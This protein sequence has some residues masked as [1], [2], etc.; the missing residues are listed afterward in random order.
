[1]NL[2]PES[3]LFGLH[4]IL[5]PPPQLRQARL[6]FHILVHSSSVSVNIL[7]C[8]I[9]NFF[10]REQTIMKG[11]YMLYLKIFSFEINEPFLIKFEYEITGYTPLKI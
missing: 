9:S 4:M 10:C 5:Q 8:D 2:D 6:N 1:M 7:F 3:N 11:K